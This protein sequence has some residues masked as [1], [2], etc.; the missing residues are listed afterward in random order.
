MESDLHVLVTVELGEAAVDDDSHHLQENEE[1]GAFE[2]LACRYFVVETADAVQKVNRQVSR[3]L[4][5]I[6]S[7]RLE[8]LPRR[9]RRVK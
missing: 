8:D 1:P 7:H 5:C 4:R 9:L 3:E 6:Q 2:D